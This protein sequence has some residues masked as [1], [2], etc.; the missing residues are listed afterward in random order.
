MGLRLHLLLERELDE[1]ARTDLLSHSQLA[2][3]API[4]HL[5]FV[6]HVA[7]NLS[8]LSRRQHAQIAPLT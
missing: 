6:N 4:N 8:G 2:G 7:M 1:L 3:L 5:S